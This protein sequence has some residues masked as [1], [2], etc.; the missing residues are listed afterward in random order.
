AK[1]LNIQDKTGKRLGEILTEQGWVE[2]KEVLRA[3][4]TQLSV[5]FARLKPGIFEPAVAEM[6]DGAIARR[7][8]VL[9][10]FLIRGQAVLAT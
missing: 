4:G 9:P 6:L 3:L 8:K 5:P 2:E 1:A 10:M 7:L